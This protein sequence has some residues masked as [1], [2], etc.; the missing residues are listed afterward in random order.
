[1]AEQEFL[2]Q[3]QGLL[4]LMQEAVAV[5]VEMLHLAVLVVPAVA[6]MAEAHGQVIQMDR[7]A[8]RTLVAEAEAV[9]VKTA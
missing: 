5:A 6:E 8:Q 7:L 9:A 3:F 4:L 1:M 2:L